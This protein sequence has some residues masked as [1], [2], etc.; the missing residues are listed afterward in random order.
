MVYNKHLTLKYNI[1]IEYLFTITFKEWIHYICCKIMEKWRN[2]F[3]IIYLL[4]TCLG[5]I[6]WKWS[7]HTDYEKIP[8]VLKHYIEKPQMVDENG[9]SH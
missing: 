5:F 3:W 6:S 7:K 9:K 1:Y 8:T 4:K 2:F